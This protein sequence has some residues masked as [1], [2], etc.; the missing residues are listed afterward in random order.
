MAQ[1]TLK[2]IRPQVVK[3]AAVQEKKHIK[4]SIEKGS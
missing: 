1:N 4:K 3:Y 2:I